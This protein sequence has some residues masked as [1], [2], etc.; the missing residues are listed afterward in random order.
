MEDVLLRPAYK[1]ELNS[2]W[3]YIYVDKEW[4]SLDAPFIPQEYQSKWQ[5]RFD[6]FKRLYLGKTAMVIQYE[7]KAVGYVTMYW[8]DESQHWLEVGITLFKSC[9]WGKRIGRKALILWVS[10]L[11]D[12]IDIPRI[13]LS[14][15]SGNTRMMK[16]AEN[17]GLTLEARIRK[18]RFYNEKYYDA[19]RYGVLRE[20]WDEFKK[21]Q[22][23]L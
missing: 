13:G 16:C 15:W 7:E 4:K 21:I 5:F 22:N 11:F 14:T 8:E 10:T 3:Y 20:E 2:L 18:V 1:N 6:L 9:H 23:T 19:V 12:Q 17:I